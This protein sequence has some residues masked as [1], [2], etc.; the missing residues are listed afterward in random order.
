MNDPQF[1]RQVIVL[2]TELLHAVRD[3]ERGLA[4]LNFEVPGQSHDQ[5][6]SGPLPE[7]TILQSSGSTYFRQPLH[8]GNFLAGRIDDGGMSDVRLELA[9]GERIPIGADE[10]VARFGALNLQPRNRISAH[11]TDRALNPEPQ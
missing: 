5:L 2:L 8:G 1:Y 7:A 10:A 6:S 4:E 9:T 11:P 3:I